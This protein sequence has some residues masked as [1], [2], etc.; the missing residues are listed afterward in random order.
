[1]PPF[2]ALLQLLPCTAARITLSLKKSDHA[3]ILMKPTPFHGLDCPHDVTLPLIPKAS[4][5]L[6]AAPTNKTH[7]FLRM[8]AFTVLSA[9][10]A[11]CTDDCMAD[12][13]STFVP[14]FKYH[15]PTK[16]FSDHQTL[17]LIISQRITLFISS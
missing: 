10:N 13:Y 16:A 12:S 1:M 7:C 6:Y 3:S 14:P 8:S 2:F 11:C 17:P 5:I 9:R 15:L 4:S